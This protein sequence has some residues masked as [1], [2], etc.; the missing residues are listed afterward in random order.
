MA[1]AYYDFDMPSLILTP[2]AG[3]GIGMSAVNTDDISST[4]FTYA[5]K[6]GVMI[7]INEKFGVDIG[8][9]FQG[10][11]LGNLSGADINS[12][13]LYNN[14]INIGLSYSL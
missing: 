11:S 2:Y 4:N 3:V 10:I 14:Q 7:P 13:T 1:N 9:T 6:A 5:F 12:G 8:Y